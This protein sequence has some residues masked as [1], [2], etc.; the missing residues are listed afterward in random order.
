MSTP[1][2]SGVAYATNRS[3]VGSWLTGKNVP[4]KR[5]IGMITNRN[6][7]ANA[8]SPSRVAENAAMGTPNAMPV[9]TAAG[10]ASSTVMW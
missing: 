3:A 9:S 10:S 4:E 6:S 7:A 1:C 5:N 8:A 2:H